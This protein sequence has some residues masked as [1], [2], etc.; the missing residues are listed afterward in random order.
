MGAYV[1]HRWA[2]SIDLPTHRGTH[3]LFSPE[4]VIQIVATVKESEPV[5][6]ALPGH[7]WTVKKVRCWIR[8]VF[9]CEVSRCTVNKLL[10]EN[11]LSWKKCQKVLAK[12]NA[13]KRATF[14]QEFQTLFDQVCGGQVRLLYIDESHF[15][16]DMDL[17][18]TWAETGKPAWRL[19]DCPP[20]SDRIDWYGAYDFSQGQ[21]FI[22]N[23]GNCN[24]DN[25]VK[26]LHHLAQWL[27]VVTCPVVIIWDGAPCHRALI[28]RAAAAELGFTLLPLPGYSPDLNPIEGLWKWMREDVTR[29]HCYATMRD[30]FDACKAFIDRIND[31]PDQLIS[32]L[33]P[34]LELNPEFEKL[35]VSK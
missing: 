23:E 17:G 9:G 16:C 4:Q 12:A 6:H 33:W 14:I 11:R 2:G 30:L 19:S 26:F 32:R 24:G 15:H 1:Q 5:A 10:Q 34:K 20:L 35:L 21:C 31:D 3:P 8:Q 25:T 22:W 18:Y 28:A 13:E 29:N 27:G 7:N